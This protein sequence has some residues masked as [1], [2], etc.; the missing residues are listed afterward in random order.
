MSTAID[1]IIKDIS[2]IHGVALGKDDPILMLHTVNKKLIE[3]NKKSHQEMLA[4]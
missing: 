2:I 4:Q 1:E 3:D